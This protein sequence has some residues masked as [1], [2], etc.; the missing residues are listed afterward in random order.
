MFKISNIND[1]SQVYTL[2]VSSA[3]AALKWT[4]DNLDPAIDWIVRA[5]N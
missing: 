1:P 2:K 3:F 5:I 4:K